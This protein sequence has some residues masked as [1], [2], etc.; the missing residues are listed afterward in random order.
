MNTADLVGEQLN[1]AVRLAVLKEMPTCEVDGDFI[2]Q[3]LKHPDIKSQQVQNPIGFPEVWIATWFDGRQNH[4]GAG[5]SEQVS[6]LRCFVRRIL[7][8]EVDL[9]VSNDNSDIK[10]ITEQPRG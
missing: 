10:V 5:S 9:P 6:K 2:D 4:M 1:L 7:G 3:L 8:H